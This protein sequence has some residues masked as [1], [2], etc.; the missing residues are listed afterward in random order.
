MSADT[1]VLA[2]GLGFPESPRWHQGQLW[3]TDHV[4]RQVLTVDATGTFQV[5]H[6]T[7]DR[8]SGI[9]W[10]PDGDLLVVAMHGRRVVRIGA[11]GVHPHAE[12]GDL[13]SFLCNDMVVAADGRA[14]VGNFGFDLHGGGE[15][16]TAELI[17]VQP[18]GAAR[19]VADELLFPNGM[20]ITPDGATLIVGET[21]GARLS[22]FAIA[23]DG[24]LGPRRTWADV[25]EVSA[26]GICLDEEGA[27]WVAS[28]ATD[29]VVRVAE[30][31]EVL[32]TLNTHGTPYACMLGGDDRRTLFVTT[33][34]GRGDDPRNAPRTGR[35]EVVEVEAA[36]VGLP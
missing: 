35:I 36:G 30:G 21:F 19:V 6:E 20:A 3:C 12:L 13:A 16:A 31:G 32:A 9:G 26:D 34:E 22:A 15:F 33:S 25:G 24:S 4:A 27:V 23:P 18:D 1:A 29:T 5:R 8:P 28:P 10:R 11:E 2:E 14:Y 7:E 17:L